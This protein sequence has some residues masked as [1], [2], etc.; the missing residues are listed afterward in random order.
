MAV[1]GLLLDDH[2]LYYRSHNYGLVETMR[3]SSVSYS[4]GYRFPC[5]VLLH[6]LFACR[7]RTITTHLSP[8]RLPSVGYCSPLLT[9]CHTRSANAV[10]RHPTCILIHTYVLR[11]RRSPPLTSSLG[12]H[13]TIF[14]AAPPSLPASPLPAH[15]CSHFALPCRSYST[16]RPYTCVALAMPRTRHPTRL[17]TISLFPRACFTATACEHRHYLIPP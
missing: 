5:F 14:L 4:L 2:Y 1:V 12:V 8:S 10:T 6:E 17:L 9:R 16:P 3:L 7:P 13:L 11:R 15:C